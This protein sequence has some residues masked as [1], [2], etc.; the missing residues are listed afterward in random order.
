MTRH[1][2]KARGDEGNSHQESVRATSYSPLPITA[3][4]P[5]LRTYDA[6]A[7]STGTFGR[8]QATI[9]HHRLTVDGP[10]QNGAPGEAPTPGE[11][12]PAAAASCSAELMEVL[13]R[14]AGVPLVRI[15]VAIRGTV[16]RGDQPR[17]GVTTFN[18]VEMDVTMQGPNAEDAAALVAGF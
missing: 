5:D 12:L 10:V 14:E 1:D 16:D 13:A 15:A 11:L 3:S 17:P 4:A 18:Q 6:S 2:G 8:V 7:V 9:R